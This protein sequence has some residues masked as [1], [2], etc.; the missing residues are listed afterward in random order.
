MIEV[1]ILISKGEE[2][3]PPHTIVQRQPGGCLPRI[4]NVRSD[5]VLT[6]VQDVLKV[7]LLPRGGIA[8]HEVA[9]PETGVHSVEGKCAARV[10]AGQV[11][12]DLAI[13]GG[14]VSDLVRS[15]NPTQILTEVE[16]GTAM[17]E[18]NCGLSI[19]RVPITSRDRESRV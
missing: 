3:L 8:Q 6:I 19:E 14:A 1:A 9:H 16:I 11:V 12:E 7:S 4:L 17:I 5:V 2:W 15:M 10:C 18:G 13:I